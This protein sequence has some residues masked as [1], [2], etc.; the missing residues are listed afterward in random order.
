[1]FCAMFQTCYSTTQR[2]TGDRC[3]GI[4][5]DKV[6]V[7]IKWEMA[8]RML[9]FL[10]S[11]NASA[12]LPLLNGLFCSKSTRPVRRVNGSTFIHVKIA[13]CLINAAS[14]NDV[15]KLIQKQKFPQSLQ[16]LH[17]IR[18]FFCNKLKSSLYQNITLFE[19]IIEVLTW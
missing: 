19:S 8:L 5:V 1:M 18:K 17:R 3:P 10:R 2:Y 7:S 16:F 15:M 9:L 11:V 4:C 13:T 14:R 12:S 6:D